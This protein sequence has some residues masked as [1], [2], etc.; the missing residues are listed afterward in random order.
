MLILSRRPGEKLRLNDDVI[1][2]VLEVKG[3]QV[4]I[5]VEA[6]ADVAIHREEIYQRIQAGT[7]IDAETQRKAD[8]VDAAYADRR[9]NA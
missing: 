2:T 3:K 6:P 1:I 5:G 4:R 8:E 9:A 7:P